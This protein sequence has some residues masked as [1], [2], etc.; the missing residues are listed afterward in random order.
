[1]E[2]KID[3]ILI[4]KLKDDNR[5]QIK[6]RRKMK[7]GFAPDDYSKIVNIHNANDICTLFE[8]LNVLFDAPI[9]TSFRKFMERKT[10]GFPF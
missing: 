3:K 10:K 4:A 2:D 1:M 9:E 7:N 8:D 6:V 5:L